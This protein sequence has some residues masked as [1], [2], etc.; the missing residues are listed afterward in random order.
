[1]GCAIAAPWFIPLSSVLFLGLIPCVI[2]LHIAQGSNLEH[3]VPENPVSYL[4]F[5]MFHQH[6]TTVFYLGALEAMRSTVDN[7]WQS[8]EAP[9][10]HEKGGSTLR[11]RDL[12]RLACLGPER[13]PDSICHDYG[14]RN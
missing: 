3:T 11:Y 5:A 13:K 9:S 7:T 2:S 10:M 14:S 6:N 12:Y 1:M 8:T 4:V